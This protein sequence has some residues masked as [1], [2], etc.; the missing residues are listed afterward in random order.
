MSAAVIAFQITAS[1]QCGMPDAE[2]LSYRM[3]GMGLTRLVLGPG[4]LLAGQP[5]NGHREREIPLEA[6]DGFCIEPMA[7]PHPLAGFNGDFVLAFR[8]GDKRRIYRLAVDVDDRDFLDVV[9][10]LGERRSEADFSHLPA[11]EAL[12]RMQVSSSARA[13][14]WMAAIAL[15][16]VAIIAL[17]MLI[18]WVRNH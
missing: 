13:G 11:A 14:L 17:V 6:I 7:A 15:G 18:L 16:G 12:A 8:D 3:N 4:S 5:R 10:A 2:Q 9:A 1:L